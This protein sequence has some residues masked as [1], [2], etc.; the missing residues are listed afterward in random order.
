MKRLDCIS[1]SALFIVAVVLFFQ[2][3]GLP[4]WGELGPA[5]GF[6]PYVLSVLLVGLSCLILLRALIVSQKGNEKP[7]II[8]PKRA[9][10]FSYVASF[11]IFGLVF[12]KIGYSLTLAVFLIFIL[13][14]V[15]KQSWRTTLMVTILSL[16]LS[17]VIFVRFLKVSMPEGW[18]TSLM[19]MIG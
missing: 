16:V 1:S 10:F 12:A 7:K 6:F 13:R 14:L 18:L 8:G 2:A 15:E 11:F 9:K 19:E 17:Y 5:E 3:G 4:F